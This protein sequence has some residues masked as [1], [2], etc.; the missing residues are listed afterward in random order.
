MDQNKID[1]LADLLNRLN[2]EGATKELREEALKLVTNI[3]PVE[4]SLAEQKL[5]QYGMD[6]E[7]LRHLCDVHMEVLSDELDKVKAQISTGHVIDTLIAEHNKI[8]D[9]LTELEAINFEIQ[10]LNNKED[11]PGLMKRL[12]ELA[13]LILDAENHH[14]REENVLFPELEKREITGPPRIMRMEHDALRLR[15]RALKEAAENVNELDFNIF[16][17]LVDETSKYIVFNLRDHIY[18]EDHILYPTALERII[19]SEIWD[20]M[21]IQCDKIGYCSFTPSV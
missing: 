15:K 13:I 12:L 18:K 9:F 11:N 20:D 1:K 19:G 4:L 6:P 5:I 8:K 17:E 2:Q 14:L 10:K 7:N 16:K 21:K 3:D